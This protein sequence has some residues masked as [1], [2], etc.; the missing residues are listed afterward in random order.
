M[1]SALIIV[2]FQNDFARP[3]GALPVPSGEAIAERI[4]AHAAT[5]DSERA[6]EELRAA[7]AIVA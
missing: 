2:D 6:L 4:N 1:A 3:D 7:G 5:G